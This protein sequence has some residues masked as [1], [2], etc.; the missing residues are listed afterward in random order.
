MTDSTQ[1]FTV[2]SKTK[3]ELLVLWKE[4]NLNIIIFLKR[5]LYFRILMQSSWAKIDIAVKIM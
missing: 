1:S 3:I 5:F 4:V 2:T